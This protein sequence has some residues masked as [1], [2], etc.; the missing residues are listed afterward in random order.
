MSFSRAVRRGVP[1]VL[2]G[3]AAVVL[4]P[5]VLRLDGRLPMIATVAWRPQAVVGAALAASALGAW[6]PTRPAGVVLGAVA[7]A[8]ATAVARRMPGRDGGGAA[9]EPLTVLSANV[10]TGRADTGRSPR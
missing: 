7:A 9:G 8:G 2:G 5:D 10:F 3:A 4:L 6:R 1:A